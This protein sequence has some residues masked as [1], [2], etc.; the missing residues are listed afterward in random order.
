[1]Q[2]QGFLF[3]KAVPAAEIPPLLRRLQ[4]RIRAA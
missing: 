3:S 4:P 2:V 1:M